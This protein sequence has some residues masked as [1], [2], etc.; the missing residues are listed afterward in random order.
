MRTLEA[1]KESER[2]ITEEEY[3]AASEIC[4][5][6]YK[7]Q[8]RQELL[9]DLEVA[10]KLVGKWFLDYSSESHAGSGKWYRAYIKIV[11]VDLEKRQFNLLDLTL[12][13]DCFPQAY[14]HEADFGIIA[15]DETKLAFGPKQVDATEPKELTRKAL[16]DFEL[17]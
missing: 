4:S 6:H 12:S 10:P 16:H 14:V 11:S 8:E 17:D 13:Q 1:A 3:K 15:E 7:Q 9:H 2:V 5:A